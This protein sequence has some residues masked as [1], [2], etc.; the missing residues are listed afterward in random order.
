[1]PLNREIL[2]TGASG[3]VGR[4]LIRDARDVGFK[5]TALVRDRGQLR[6]DGIELVVADL[7]DPAADWLARLPPAV[8]AVVHL[9]QSSHFR[10][11]PARAG[12]VL[13]V[14]TVATAH[15]LDYS[16]RA[17]VRTFVLASTGGVYGSPAMAAG[18]LIEEP[19]RYRSDIGFYAATKLAAEAIADAYREL[20]T[21]V[22]LRGFFIY[23]PGQKPHMLVPRLIDRVLSSQPITV[24]GPRG[25]RFNPLF[26]EDCSRAIIAALDV[27]SSMAVNVAGPE[28]TDLVGFCDRIGQLV[29][30]PPVYQRQ[31]GTPPDWT[32]DIAMMRETFGPPRVGITA[33]IAAVL[34]ARP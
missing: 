4:R 26:V 21:I 13:A 11:F 34:Q 2:V 22:N 20:F 29:G 9:A 17:G 25:M 18:P 1:M 32:A 14:N 5:V 27:S 3:L 24:Q 12:H 8:D 19:L 33:G 23:G 10:E 7:A 15:L 30:I 16:R 6:T 28:A 31:E